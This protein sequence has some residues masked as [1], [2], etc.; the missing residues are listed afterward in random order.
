MERTNN[1]YVC[2]V[3]DRQIKNKVANF[4]R[5]MELH[6]KKHNRVECNY[7]DKDFQNKSNLIRHV[8]DV[9]KVNDYGAVK[10]EQKDAK[11]GFV[12]V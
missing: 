10:I 7:C 9:H 6:E 11:S 2:P 8:N 4:R 1:F 3:C 12:C 5:H